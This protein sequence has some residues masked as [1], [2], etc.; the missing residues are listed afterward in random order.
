MGAVRFFALA[1]ST[2]VDCLRDKTYAPLCV[3]RENYVNLHHQN[4]LQ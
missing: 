2:V 1:A 4:L 3:I